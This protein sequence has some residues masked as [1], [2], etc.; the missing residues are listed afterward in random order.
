MIL[1]PTHASVPSCF[2]LGM[3]HEDHHTPGGVHP[4]AKH[5]A[6]YDYLPSSVESEARLSVS[7]LRNKRIP[8]RLSITMNAVDA[9]DTRQPR[10][11]GVYQLV[12][13]TS[14]GK[15]VWQHTCEDLLI[16]FAKIDDEDG[17]IIAQATCFGIDERCCARLQH[18]R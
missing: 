11:L 14:R 6:L 17:W 1:A 15:P 9:R 16:A 8:K 4:P 18:H 3:R 10:V 13:A 2:A 7:A 5:Q 12:R